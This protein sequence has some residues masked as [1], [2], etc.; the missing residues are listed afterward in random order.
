MGGKLARA[1]SVEFNTIG[2]E[3]GIPLDTTIDKSLLRPRVHRLPL[4][5]LV[6]RDLGIGALPDLLRGRGAELS[7]LVFGEKYPNFISVT[8]LVQH[9]VNLDRVDVET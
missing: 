5:R 6:L 7:E 3:E 1:A 2:C 8:D 9:C 4:H